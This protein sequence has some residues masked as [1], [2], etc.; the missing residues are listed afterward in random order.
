MIDAIVVNESDFR[1]NAGN[2]LLASLRDYQYE[3]QNNSHI[4]ILT[5]LEFIDNNPFLQI[6]N[7]YLVMLKKKGVKAVYIMLN[8]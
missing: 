6:F 5:G 1:N 3:G 2:E 4:K 8:K 7:K